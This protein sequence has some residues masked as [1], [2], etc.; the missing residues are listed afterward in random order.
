[1]G[2][3]DRTRD[4]GKTSASRQTF[5][6]GK[7][8]ELA[9]RD[10]RGQILRLANAGEDA[11][12]KFDG[13]TLTVD[14]KGAVRRIALATLPRLNDDGD[15]LLGEGRFDPPTTMLDENG[16]GVP[17]ATYGFAAQMALVEEIGS[18]HV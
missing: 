12:L 5:V 1:M 10:L 16:Q 14:D 4:A 18:A 15:V 3:T 13:T 7:A 8:V 11:K 9:G 2:D 17:Y 6:S